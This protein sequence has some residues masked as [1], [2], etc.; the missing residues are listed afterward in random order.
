MKPS[1]STLCLVAALAAAPVSAQSLSRILSNSGLSPDDFNI[2]SEAARTLYDRANP[3]VGSETKWKNDET[4]SF[5]TVKLERFANG[6][7]EVV[8]HVQPGAREGTRQVNSKFCRT[9][10]GKWV[11]T[12]I[13]P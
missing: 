1:I 5:G 12:P 9:A 4:G 6:C 8:H 3:S 2:M 11:L 10:E 7:A 13:Q